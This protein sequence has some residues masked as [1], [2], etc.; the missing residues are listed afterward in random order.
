MGMDQNTK[1]ADEAPAA[2]DAVSAT[3]SQCHLSQIIQ[4]VSVS[5]SLGRR[6]YMCFFTH[7]SEKLQGLISI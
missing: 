2:G 4:A 1:V 5:S 3:G 6:I 7:H